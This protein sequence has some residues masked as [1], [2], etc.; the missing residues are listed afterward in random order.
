MAETVADQRASQALLKKALTVLEG[1][2]G[3]KEAALAQ[4][5]PVGPPPPPGFKEYKKNA[6]SGGVM[7]EI[8]QIIEDAEAMEKEAI[9]FEG[10]AVASYEAFVMD[11]NASIEA[12]VK[13]RLRLVAERAKREAALVETKKALEETLQTLR[14]SWRRR[15]RWRRRY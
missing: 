1:F 2:Y 8:T 9:K 13:E 15:R 5:E 10:D 12:K 3:K 14:S 11:T 7:A 6:Q 4:Q